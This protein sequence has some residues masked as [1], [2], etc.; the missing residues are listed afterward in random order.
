MRRGAAALLAA[1]LGVGLGSCSEPA[2]APWHDEARYRWRELSVGRGSPGFTSLEGGR[3]GI[4]FENTVSDSVLTGNRY[5]GEYFKQNFHITTSGNFCDATFKCCLEVMGTDRVL[6]SAD[7]P[8]ETME[9][10]ARWFDNTPLS[11]SDRL[12]IGRTNAIELFKLPL[13]G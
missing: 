9:D 10:A 4:R 6:F 12:R 2:P 5:L 11:D 7:Y 3:T 8:F 1:L 13:A